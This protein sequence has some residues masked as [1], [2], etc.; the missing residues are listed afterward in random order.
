M[1]RLRIYLDTSIFGGVFDEEFADSSSRFVERAKAGE[2]TILV[3][4]S[5][6]LELGNA[7]ERVQRILQEIPRE[8][9]EFVPFDEET[10]TLADA[11]IKAEV[12]GEARREDA[13]HIAAA[14]VAGADLMLSW[15]FKHI[16]RYD[17]I[18]KFNGVNALKG[19]T[20]LDIRSPLEVQY[21]E[22]EEGL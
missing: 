13:N 6:L 10:R 2:Y 8:H 20:A 1:R 12:L 16:V 15:N 18:R 9:M 21:G 4:Q 7:P 22:N 11:Y 17:R 3:S 14:S 19:Y 5:T